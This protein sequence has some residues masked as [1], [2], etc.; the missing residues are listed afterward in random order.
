MIYWTVSEITYQVVITGVGGGGGGGRHLEQGMVVAEC[1]AQ[2]L[3]NTSFSGA[4]IQLVQRHYFRVT[5]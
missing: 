3:L 1:Y 2:V 5:I 4:L